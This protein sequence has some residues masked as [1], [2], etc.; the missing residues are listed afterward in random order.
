MEQRKLS[1][2]QVRD[3][4]SWLPALIFDYALLRN[5]LVRNEKD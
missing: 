1:G 3:S 2:E 5:A 4:N